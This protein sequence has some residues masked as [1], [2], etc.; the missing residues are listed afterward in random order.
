M[1]R[2]I[3]TEILSEPW[4]RRFFQ[5]NIV[6]P[7]DSAARELLK[8]W[9][10]SQ[11]TGGRRFCASKLKIDCPRLTKLVP[12]QSL[13]EFPW[14]TG[15]KKHPESARNRYQ[16]VL[17]ERRSVFHLR[18]PKVLKSTQWKMMAYMAL[19]CQPSAQSAK[20][21]TEAVALQRAAKL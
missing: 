15:T 17:S 18:F 5:S 11:P 19:I 12:A 7:S 20:R 4:I 8:P 10:K 13:Q 3:P 9:S 2:D 16:L 1:R 21:S 14:E 6:E